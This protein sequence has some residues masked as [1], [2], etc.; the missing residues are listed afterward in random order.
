MMWGKTKHPG[1]SGAGRASQNRVVRATVFRAAGGDIF[2]MAVERRVPTIDLDPPKDW[3][4]RV[5]DVGP[6]A[7]KGGNMRLQ[8][9]SMAI[10]VLALMV[11]TLAQAETIELVAV[12]D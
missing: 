9:A 2:S 7:A 5:L 4:Q 11:S 6:Y 10:A 3:A 8:L 1:I 12:A